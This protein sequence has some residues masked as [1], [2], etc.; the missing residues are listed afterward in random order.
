LFSAIQQKAATLQK[1][2]AKSQ[3]DGSKLRSI[4]MSYTASL[5][6]SV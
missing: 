4:P 5:C 1:P 6:S 2:K 3:S